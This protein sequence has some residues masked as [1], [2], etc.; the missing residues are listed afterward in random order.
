MKFL[1]ITELAGLVMFITIEFFEHMDLFTS[2]FNNFMLSIAYITLRIPFYVNLMLPLAFLISILVLIIMM[3]RSNEIIAA[4]TSG[5]S[6]ISLMKPL[7][8]FA[9]GLVVFSFIVSE[10]IM[11]YTA[12]AADYLY[13][14]KIKKEAS[15]VFFK[16]DKIWFKRDN[17]ISNIDLFD[18]KKDTITG[19]TVMELSDDFTISRRIDARTGT[20]QGSSWLFSSVVERTFENNTIRSKKTYDELRDLIKVSPAALKVSEKNPED[21]GYKDLSK[22]IRRLKHDGHDVRRY[23]VD[24]YNKIAFPFINLIMVFAAFSV[25]LR[26]TKT[27]HIAKGVFSGISVGA[28]YW[29]LHSICLSLGYSEIFPPVFAV[30]LS[31]MLFFSSGIIGI[32][33]LRT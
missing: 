17:V 28:L 8:V 6:T 21:M 16:N 27:K 31:N 32:V 12:N 13:R 10:W 26:Y 15:R 33:T 29:F 30:W 23:L 7:I 18:T 2:S 3:V 22:Y 19:L 9:I 4:R 11:P 24:L 14:V 20:W 5:I 25:G 1:V